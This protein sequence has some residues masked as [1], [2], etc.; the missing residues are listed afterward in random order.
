MSLTAAETKSPPAQ[1]GAAAPAAADCPAHSRASA[2]RGT[3]HVTGRRNSSS[4]AH[5]EMQGGTRGHPRLIFTQ[6]VEK[7][8]VI[9][10]ECH[11]DDGYGIGGANAEERPHDKK[12]PYKDSIGSCYT[13]LDKCSAKGKNIG[14][15]LDRLVKNLEE[16]I[17]D[18]PA[19]AVRKA[20]RKPAE[21]MCCFAE[22]ILEPTLD[23]CDPNNTHSVAWIDRPTSRARG[24][25]N[26]TFFKNMGYRGQSCDD[27]NTLMR[28][29]F[30]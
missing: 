3:R 9:K 11:G 4:S 18:T 6:V 1:K 12:C 23:M 22:R 15:N 16:K 26:S 10:I 25:K 2:P 13:S 24:K 27:W 19:K 5:V 20:V 8:E 21:K 7:K 29:S 28:Y 17:R 14:E 30:D